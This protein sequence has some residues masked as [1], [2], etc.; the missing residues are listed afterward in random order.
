MFQT[1]NQIWTNNDKRN[2]KIT[3]KRIRWNHNS[4]KQIFGTIWKHWSVN[5]WWIF[6]LLKKLMNISWFLAR[7]AP[8]TKPKRSVYLLWSSYVLCCGWLNHP[9]QKHPP[10]GYSDHQQSMCVSIRIATSCLQG[11][12][13]KS[14]QVSKTW[15]LGQ[16]V[17]IYACFDALLIIRF[18]SGWTPHHC[19]CWASVLAPAI[20]T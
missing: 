15:F 17:L 20:S 3:K 10:E 12:W 5:S 11:I 9:F 16:F 19:H 6:R 8:E 2:G 1:T 4:A 18:F 7:R 14:F 13:S